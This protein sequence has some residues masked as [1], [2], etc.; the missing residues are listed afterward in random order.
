MAQRIK[1]ATQL[2]AIDSLI[3]ATDSVIGGMI[4]DKYLYISQ[5]K[6]A[7]QEYQYMMN[8]QAKLYEASQEIDKA[9]K[10]I[11]PEITNLNISKRL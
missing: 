11:K 6:D 4:P 5:R 7:P 1:L 8:A 2:I 3:H 10:L 9:K